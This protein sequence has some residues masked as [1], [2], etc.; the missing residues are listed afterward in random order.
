MRD[1]LAFDAPTPARVDWVLDQ[2]FDLFDRLGASDEQ[3][4]FPTLYASA[5]GGYAGLD[6]GVHDADMGLILD[7]ILSTCRHSM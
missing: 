4:D 1:N 7:A 6:A 2:T 3:R 5:L